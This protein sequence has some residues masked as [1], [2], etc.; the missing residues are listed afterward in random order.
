[1]SAENEKFTKSANQFRLQD[2]IDTTQFYH[3]KLVNLKREMATLSERSASMKQRGLR[4]QEAKQKE[5][6][7]R[8]LKRQ[9]DQELEDHLVAKPVSSS[10]N[11]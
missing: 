6:L 3:E 4:L 10:K 1:M 8:E 11:Q 7:R 9:K 5:A 2:L